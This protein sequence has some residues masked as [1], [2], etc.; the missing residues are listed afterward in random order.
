MNG[1]N[2]SKTETLRTRCYRWLEAR[3]TASHAALLV[4]GLLVL[5]IAVAVTA[6][7]LATLPDLDDRQQQLLRHLVT[8]AGV[9][10]ALE[11]LCRI[12]VAPERDPVS[13]AGPWGARWQYLRSF[14]GVIDLLVVLPL[15]HGFAFAAADDGLALVT[16]LAL[17]KL[18]RYAKPLSLFVAVFRTE[19]RALLSGL[20]AMLMLMVLLAGLMF[21][22]EHPAQPE[23]FRSIPDAMW[24]AVVTMATV[25]YGDI[26]PVTAL[27]KVTGGLTMLLG[28]AMFAVPAGILANGFA[29]EIRKRDF[30]VTWQTVASV[31]LFASLDAARIASI[32]Q[33]LKPQVLPP[34][35]V[36][37]RHGEPAD[38]MYFIMAGEVEVDLQPQPVRLGKGQYFGEIALI[39]DTVRV[40]TVTTLSEC[41]LL[42][43]QVG[44]FRR[45]MAEYPEL[46]AAIERVADERLQQQR[47]PSRPVDGA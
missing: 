30:I 6:A 4:Q 28:I 43:L 37:V 31:P 29:A 8:A 18:G 38:A 17:I 42:A 32:A 35:Q 16:L 1:G 23:V 40:A 21:V 11:Y 19:G 7:V 14:L 36:V 39:R 41:Q 34:R 13:L 15:L 44:D 5:A 9:V 2:I 3:E 33:L 26:T 10:F 12:W 27:G 20:A 22:L 25:G 45:L 47:Q 24:W 46:K